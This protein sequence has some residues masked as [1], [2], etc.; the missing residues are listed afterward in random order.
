MGCKHQ[1]DFREVKAGKG[2]HDIFGRGE[3]K[4]SVVGYNIHNDQKRGPHGGT[5]AMVFGMLSN[6]ARGDTKCNPSGLGQWTSV[7]VSCGTKV[8][9][10]LRGGVLTHFLVP[11]AS[12][13]TWLQGWIDVGAT[14]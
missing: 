14:L 11:T 13:R 2:F 1:T 10:S 3:D 12:K 7:V 4:K 8:V 5:G 6:Y 9:R